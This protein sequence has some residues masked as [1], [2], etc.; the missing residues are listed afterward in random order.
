M[1]SS[2]LKI[3]AFN[4]N[5]RKCIQLKYSDFNLVKLWNEKLGILKYEN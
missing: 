3:S 4:P 1:S 5:Y 2:Q